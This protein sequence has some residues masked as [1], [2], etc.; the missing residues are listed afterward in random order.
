MIYRDCPYSYKSCPYY[1][2]DDGDEY[3]C[4]HSTSEWNCDWVEQIENPHYLL[5]DSYLSDYDYY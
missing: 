4:C 1:Y 3:E 5:D 2:K